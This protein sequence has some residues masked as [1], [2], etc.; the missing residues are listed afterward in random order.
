MPPTHCVSGSDSIGRHVSRELIASAARRGE[1]SVPACIGSDAA[2]EL[3]RIPWVRRRF[4][5]GFENLPL[6]V[7]A[8]NHCLQFIDGGVVL[9]HQNI[10]LF[11]G[12][13]FLFGTHFRGILGG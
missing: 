8:A 13:L 12:L 3:R 9:L 4:L 7:E 5:L 2:R 6:L 10:L 1:M 11:G